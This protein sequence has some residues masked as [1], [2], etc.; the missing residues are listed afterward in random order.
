MRVKT[1]FFESF[2][3]EKRA[4]DLK[5]LIERLLRFLDST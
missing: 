5:S 3:L 1:K 4:Y 2:N